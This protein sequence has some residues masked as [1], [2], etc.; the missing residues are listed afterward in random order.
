ME[1]IRS[2]QTKGSARMPPPND[3]PATER[4][5]GV[6]LDAHGVLLLPDPDALARVL[7]PLGYD[8]QRADCARAHYEL[9]DALARSGPEQWS[10]GLRHFALSIGVTSPMGLGAV[11]ETYLGSGWRA[12]PGAG[13]ALRRIAEAGIPIAVLS[14]SMYGDTRELLVRCG[15]TGVV[16]SSPYP[17]AVIDSQYVGCSKPDPRFFTLAA[18][19]IDVDLGDCV[20]IGDGVVEDVG[21]AQAAGATAV[22]I[23]PL[24][25]CT[26]LDHSHAE[27]LST[28]VDG[29]LA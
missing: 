4:P 23:D 6:F 12:A 20:H 14:N 3:S 18:T 21:G 1:P 17:A 13:T 8:I 2:A 26:E 22:H 27:D 24:H 28:A 16:A 29:L 11:A 9:V 5:R 10:T 7:E 15:L 25:L 19:A